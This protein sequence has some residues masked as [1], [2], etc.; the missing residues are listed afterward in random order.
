MQRE[1]QKITHLTGGVIR[2]AQEDSGQKLLLTGSAFSLVTLDGLA[3]LVNCRQV[4]EINVSRNALESL[5][6]SL[7]PFS[8]LSIL[9]ASN[10]FI[11]EV[12]FTIA[13]L[14]ELDLSHNRLR[15][16]PNLNECNKLEKLSL[17]YNQLSRELKNLKS[18]KNLRTLS[19]LS[20]IHI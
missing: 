13:S 3:S 1:F 9:L 4:R 14:K 8:S 15:A 12:D 10:N 2:Q 6:A 5:E 19:L 11:S 17:S 18:L 20:L 7:N 16:V